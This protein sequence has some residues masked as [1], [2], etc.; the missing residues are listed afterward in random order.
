MSATEVPTI[1]VERTL[2]ELVAERPARARVLER[3]G[4]DYCCHGH[5]RLLDAATDAG[6]DPDAVAAALAVVTDTAG[7]E[8]D[9]LDPV[10][11]VDHIVDTHHA[12]LHEQLPLLDALATKVRDVHGGR[13]PELVEVARLVAEIRA[14]LEP[15]LAK[16]EMVLFPAIRAAATS[17][18]AN[19]VRVLMAEHDRAGE[20]LVEVRA[21]AQDYVVPDDGC[22][23]F[24]SLYERLAHLEADTHRHIHLENNVLFPAVVAAG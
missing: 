2:G 22:A 23:S 11:L 17:A 5:R 3:A 10:A 1:D 18:I 14:E 20:L 8:V 12:Y 13:H 21:A 9:G 6:L 19:P 7:V 24:T 15:H 4:I 16:E